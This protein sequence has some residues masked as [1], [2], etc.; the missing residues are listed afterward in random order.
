MEDEIRIV[1]DKETLSE[2]LKHYFDKYPKRRVVPIKG[3]IPPSLNQWSTMPRH[4][5]NDSKQKWKEFGEWVVE[6]YGLS[7]R[8]VGLCD[9][10]V[11]YYYGDKRRRDLDN[12]GTKQV[13]DAFVDSGLF[14]DDDYRHV[15][16][17]TFRG[18]YR[19]GNPSM[20]FLIFAREGEEEDAEKNIQ[21]SDD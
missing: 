10:E 6:N 9:V 3:P 1:F 15:R 11:Q 7:N 4:Q 20:E 19:K 2:Y 13:F 16:S 12:Y 8:K 17:L 5:A 14:V 18:G 21:E